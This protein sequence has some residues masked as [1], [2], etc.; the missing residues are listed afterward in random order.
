MYD[1]IAARVPEARADE[2]I[3]GLTLASCASNIEAL[4]SMIR[5]GIPASAT[6]APVAALEHARRMA[7]RGAGI[8][9]TLRFYRNG[10]W[11]LWERFS[12]AIVAAVREEDRLVVAL[13][14]AAGF[15][16]T[17]VDLV[18]SRVSAELLAERDRRQRRTAAL[19]SEIVRAL[20]AGE[21]IELARAESGLGHSLR[22]PQVAFFCWGTEDG[23]ALERAAAALAEAAGSSRPLLLAEDPGT[24]AGWVAVS[25]RE[26][27]FAAVAEATAAAAGGVH[28]AVGEVARGGD[29]F[30]LTREQAERARRVARLM[31]RRAPTFT[32]Y[33]DVA[34]VDLLSTDLV[35]A[36]ALV[37]AELG[38]LARADAATARLR[39]A[40]LAVSAP[41]G[42]LAAAA[43]SLGVHRNTVLQR[44]RRAEELRGAPAS[45]R[46]DELR[47]ALLLVEAL[48]AGVLEG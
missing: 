15:M 12:V 33:G 16:F 46:A 42:G 48:G 8:D 17:Y 41:H 21:P 47:A 44:V 24:L 31:G 27:A 11:Y 2:E 14:E 9:A 4:L 39:E 40:L 36:R 25:G 37:R 29:A 22:A 18:S 32:R 35:A 23:A 45:E 34:L 6:E 13:R 3:A 38:P 30:R 19:R 10:Q 43:R 26:F 20:L 1:H 5:H 7:A 28:V